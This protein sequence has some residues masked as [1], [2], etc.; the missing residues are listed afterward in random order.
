LKRSPNVHESHRPK[1][2]G[3]KHAKN[4][5]VNFWGIWIILAVLFV[6]TAINISGLTLHPD[7]EMHVVEAAEPPVFGKP[8]YVGSTRCK[9]CHWREYDTW[10]NTLHSKFMQVPGE[11][12]IIGDF[13]RDNRL[14]VNVVSNSPRMAGEEAI[15]TM[16]KRDGKYY[17]NTTGPDWELHDYEI[18]NV[19]GIGRKQNY[20]TKFPNGEMH[21]LPVQWNV[22]EKEWVALDG[23]KENYP[24]E[25]NYWSDAGSTWQLTCA[26][27]HVTG[28]KI[29]Y[30]KEENS[31]DSTWT[32]RGIA[33]EACH[34]PGSNHIKAASEY[35]DY[36]KENIINPAK[37]PWRLRAMVC[38]QCH[39][40][41]ASTV[42][43]YPAGEGFP[44][45]YG[46]PYGYLPGKA[47][48][49]A[50]DEEPDERKKHH[51]Q[52][53][54][55]ESSEHAKKG[56]MCTDC[57]SVHQKQDTKISMTKLAADNLCMDCHKTLKRRAAHRI[58]TFGSCVSCHMPETK[59]HEHSH[60][61]KFI[62]PKESII[63][64]GVDKQ[65]NSCNGCHHHKDTPP[66]N[67]V[68]FINAVKMADMPRP[69]TVHGN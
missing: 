66:E 25:G 16:F 22:M 1:H 43:I 69:Y 61:F 36:E 41:G 6:L 3:A 33:C 55:W 49:L 64:G 11:Y 14:V 24:G 44:K 57:H 7:E 27:C 35:F 26:G 10:K 48:Y 65:P 60:T 34:G 53:N 56:I 9:D 50:Y 20:L 59:G 67:L 15:T 17:V 13:A 29:N 47:L 23:L 19:I 52:Y 63:A 39:N 18:I 68:E 5:F 54:E 2:H 62:S 51:Q 21:I 46:F 8:E 58:H 45:Q 28:L 37:L 31:F 30:T 42:D 12:T 38:G 4:I 32:D 40:W